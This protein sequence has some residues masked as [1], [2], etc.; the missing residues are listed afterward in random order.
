MLLERGGSWV[1]EP[2]Q[3]GAP[4]DSA[5][6]VPKGVTIGAYGSGEKPILRGDIETANS[7][8]FWELYIE[9]NGTKIWKAAQSVYYC[10]IIA[11][12][13][14]TAYASPVMPGMDDKGQYLSDDGSAFEIADGLSRD[15][16]FCC[17]L[18]L[19]ELG[20]NTNVE[21]SLDVWG[22]LYLR[23]DSGNPAEVYESIHIPQ[24]AAGL[25]LDTGVT[26]D[27]ISIRYFTCNGIISAGYGGFHSQSITN[28]EVGWCGGLIHGYQQNYLDVY[29]PFAAGGAVQAST[30]KFTIRD[31]YLHHCGPFT[32]IFA[33]HH[34]IEDLSACIL[35][36]EDDYIANNLI[37]YCGSGI[38]M[39]DYADGDIPG[40]KGYISN[41]VFENNYV[42]NSGMGWVRDAVWQYDSGSSPYI[43]AFENMQSAIDNDGIYLRNNVFYKGAFALFSLSDYHLSGTPVTALPVFSGNTY[44]QSAN[45]PI[46]QKNWTKEVYYPT[47]DVVKEVLGDDTG[48]LVIIGE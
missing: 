30:T 47:E 5:L 9:Q 44:V 13:K 43:S 16:Q 14:G 42:M 1:I 41:F 10:P 12:N 8:E 48:S 21:D 34:N 25:H 35:H 38:H 39:G 15:L 23:C 19:T 46:L 2:A 29:M 26:L 6:M 40:T 31:S 3:N 17:L 32:L 24:T 4:T 7:P 45:K 11:F 28:C 37:E 36:Y 27:N 22:E 20:V 33:V 18:D